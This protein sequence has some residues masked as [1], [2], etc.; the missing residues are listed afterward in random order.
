[1]GTRGSV[2]RCHRKRPC[3][4]GGPRALPQNGVP[5]APSWGYIL[6]LPA[7]AVTLIPCDVLTPLF[8]A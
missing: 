2:Q 6:V 7:G 8:S 1:M 5:W 4:T 3:E